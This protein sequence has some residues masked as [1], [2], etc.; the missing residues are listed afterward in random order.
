MCCTISD[1]GISDI[2][3]SLRVKPLTANLYNSIVI[4]C[5][6][7]LPVIRG[8]VR[9]LVVGEGGHTA[10]TP[11]AAAVALFPH[12]HQMM[13]TAYYQYSISIHTDSVI[14]LINNW[15]IRLSW[16]SRVH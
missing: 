1:Q 10:V 11:A 16:E 9:T 6:S 8:H 13:P 15:S 7:T 4:D 5:L 14:S 2:V 12:P 3:V